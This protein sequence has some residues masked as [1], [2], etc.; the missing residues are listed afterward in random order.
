M[1]RN[2]YTKPLI[3]AVV[4]FILGLSLLLGSLWLEIDTG[5]MGYFGMATI[6]FMITLSGVVTWIIYG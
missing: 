6:G 1:P 2:L 3:V 5:D 4:L